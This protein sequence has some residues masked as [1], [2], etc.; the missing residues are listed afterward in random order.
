MYRHIL[1]PLDGSPLA[2][3]ILEHVEPLAKLCGAKLSLLR[4][5]LV[6]TVP[7]LDPT[8]DQVRVVREAEEYLERVAAG[9][10]ARGMAVD[11][12]VRYGHDAQE[13]LDHAEHQDVDLV[14]MGSHGQSG[15]TRWNLGGVTKRVV[16]YCARPVLT[17]R[18]R[19]A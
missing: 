8:E 19:Q 18:V 11:T 6:R 12:H 5:A 7:G 9:L 17:V 3:R 2:E 1:V 15:I 4:V 14:A 16:T 13:I 10:R